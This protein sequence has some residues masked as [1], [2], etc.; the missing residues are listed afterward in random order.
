M[1]E[2]DTSQVPSYVKWLRE[3]ARGLELEVRET[4]RAWAVHIHADIAV[5]TPQ[6]SG[7]LAANWA[8]DL[9]A[10]TYTAQ[11]LGDPE[12]RPA[13]SDISPVFGRDPYSRGMLP[14]VDDSLE[15]GRKF[16]LPKLTDVI[17]IHN[18]V[19]YAMDIETDTSSP[20][21]RAINRLPRTEAGKIAMVYH[22]FTKYS[23]RGA[24]FLN[25]LRGR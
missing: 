12:V 22:A 3:Q 24:D 13:G 14:A 25:E 19:S 2:I 11:E 1:L 16:T 5:L 18:P 9:N 8:I 15:R 6:W 10:K 17:Y 4:Y 7:N 23:A 21:V 20:R